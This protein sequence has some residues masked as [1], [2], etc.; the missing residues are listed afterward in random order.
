MFSLVFFT[1]LVAFII[2][3]SVGDTTRAWWRGLF[4][5]LMIVI[6]VYWRSYWLKL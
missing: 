1:L 5:S 4:L 3:V 6:L 2:R